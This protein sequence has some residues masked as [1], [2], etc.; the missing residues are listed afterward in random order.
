MK[1]LFLSALLIVLSS[2]VF[3][4]K[5][6]EPFDFYVFDMSEAGGLFQNTLRYME[7]MEDGRMSDPEDIAYLLNV[8]YVRDVEEYEM[9]CLFL[10]SY[11]RESRNENVQSVASSFWGD[12]IN[13]THS[14]V[15]EKNYGAELLE[16]E[17]DSPGRYFYAEEELYT[18]NIRF[19][20]LYTLQSD[21]RILQSFIPAARWNA[22]RFSEN[23]SRTSFLTGGR[24]EALSVVMNQESYTETPVVDGSEP[25]L[26]DLSAYGVSRQNNADLT[27]L[28]IIT[29]SDNQFIFKISLY[30]ES[31]KTVYSLR[32]E[33]NISGNNIN[34]PVFSDLKKH[35]LYYSFLT[36]LEP[37]EKSSDPG[38][39]TYSPGSSIIIA[40]N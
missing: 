13:E 27:L 30:L 36:Y 23:S 4:Q 8:A 21:D 24:S 25:Y 26:Y 3:P 28:E 31:A 38:L 16:G 2:A 15:M 33:Y 17:G 32:Y 12:I 7:A 22:L 35:L 14:G 29:D 6:D 18:E 19:S 37:V 9:T 20:Q 1:K 34:F 5:F 39:L 11:F 40:R 10:Q